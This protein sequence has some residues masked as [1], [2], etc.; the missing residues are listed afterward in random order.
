MISPAQLLEVPPCRLAAVRGHA[1]L[2]NLSRTIRELF[3][4]FYRNPPPVA[5]GLNAVLYH[6]D[7]AGAGA[8]ID[9][10]SR[11]SVPSTPPGR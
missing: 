8:T 5:R 2:A 9:V 6:G 4:R 1:S 10:G 7:P 11:F 3:D